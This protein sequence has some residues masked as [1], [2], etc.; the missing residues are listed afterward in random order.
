MLKSM[1]LLAVLTLPHGC[2]GKAPPKPEPLLK[3]SDI[4]PSWKDGAKGKRLKL[5]EEIERAPV[6]AVWP[7]VMIADQGLKDQLTAAKCPPVN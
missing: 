7:E 6:D 3:T 1:L 4:C 2:A 5:A